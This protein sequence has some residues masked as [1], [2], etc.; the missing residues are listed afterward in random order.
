M[1]SELKLEETLVLNTQE[2]SGLK[3]DWLPGLHKY[4]TSDATYIPFTKELLT[5]TQTY[6]KSCAW[7]SE[8]NILVGQEVQFV[9]PFYFEH[10][11]RDISHGICDYC[12]RNE[13]RV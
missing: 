2:T 7:C 5:Q 10:S 3:E 13:W 9:F 12:A 6:D 1:N 4:M 11:Y 8:P